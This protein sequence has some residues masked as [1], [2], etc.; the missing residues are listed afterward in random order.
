MV[1]SWRMEAQSAGGCGSS[2]ESRSS[3]NGVPNRAIPMELE[4]KTILKIYD[5]MI[6]GNPNQMNK[7]IEYIHCTRGQQNRHMHA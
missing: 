3:S 4:G 1:K 2:F 6:A 7:I 5:I